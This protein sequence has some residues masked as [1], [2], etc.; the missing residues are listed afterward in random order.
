[1]LRPRFEW[2]L[3]PL[4]AIMF[5][6]VMDCVMVLLS[7]QRFSTYNSQKLVFSQ[8]V[9]VLVSGVSK[10]DEVMAKRQPKRLS[11]LVGPARTRFLLLRRTFNFIRNSNKIMF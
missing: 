9:D 7:V 8:I 4:C 3:G 2:G 11:I 6:V 1:M 5:I 10:E